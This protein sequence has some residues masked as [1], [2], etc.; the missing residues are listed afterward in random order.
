MIPNMWVKSCKNGTKNG[1]RGKNPDLLFIVGLLVL[2]ALAC[3]LGNSVSEPKAPIAAID[4]SGDL[5]AIK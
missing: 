1:S 4:I 5:A 2:P 3:G